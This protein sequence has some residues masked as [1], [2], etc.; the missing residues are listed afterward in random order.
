[1]NPS[2]MKFS[3]LL[4]NF[5]NTNTRLE[6]LALLSPCRMEHPMNISASVLK[7]YLEKTV[8]LKKLYIHCYVTKED[9]NEVKW[10]PNPNIE[11]LLFQCYRTR[12]PLKIEFD[13][14]M[15]K[16]TFLALSNID[17]EMLESIHPFR[18]TLKK[19]LPQRFLL[20]GR[21]S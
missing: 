21:G 7:N 9:Q 3:E 6:T 13:Q 18:D 12:S 2:Q 20:S 10:N 17:E 14:A 4:K 19:C 11:E 5:V 15:P 8:T 1:M 16:L